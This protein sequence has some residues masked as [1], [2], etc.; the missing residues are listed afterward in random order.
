MNRNIEDRIKEA[1]LRFIDQIG[2]GY[3]VN[4]FVEC[5]RAMKLMFEL[6]AEAC[7]E[8]EFTS[9]VPKTFNEEVWEATEDIRKEIFFMV[10]PSRR[11]SVTK[12]FEKLENFLKKYEDKIASIPEK[13]ISVGDEVSFTHGE[14]REVTRGIVS[15]IYQRAVVQAEDSEGFKFTEDSYLDHFKLIRKCP[16]T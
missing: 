14:K 8:L 10:P 15:Y 13:K 11:D 7:E 12:S 5:Y 4:S 3:K 16:K 6:L 1:K 2:G 9:S